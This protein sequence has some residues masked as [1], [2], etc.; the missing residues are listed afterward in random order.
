MATA[1]RSS[2]N[3]AV[4]AGR[5]ATSGPPDRPAVA[6][7]EAFMAGSRTGNARRCFM[8]TWLIFAGLMGAPVLAA[9]PQ[10]AFN[11]PEDAV[12]A[13]VGAVQK[14][15]R[16]ALAT[17][18]GPGSEALIRS[19]DAVKDRQEGQSFL[20]AYAAKHEVSSVDATHSVLHV[21]ANDWPLPI[22]IVQS[23]GKWRFDSADGAQQIIDRR[24]G[25]NEIA[26]I[27]FCL[28]YVDAQKAYFELFKQA[29]GSGA[30]AQHLV[31]TP[32]NYDGLYWPSAANIPDS[33]LAQVAADAVAE[34]YPSQVEA[35]KGLPY[36]GYFYRILTA[37][38]AAAPDGAKSFLHNGKMTEG[39]ALIAWPA[40]YGASGIMSF[41][42]NQDGIV[43]Q[44]DLG[45]NTASRVA[46]AKIFNPDLD[47]A[48]VDIASQ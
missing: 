11:S 27:E 8:A 34:G 17:V 40:R 31:S 45:P 6:R 48:R 1:R 30:Y 24:I 41:I 32:G 10:Q 22:P 20:D 42:V 15:D 47:W 5:W 12:A 37:Q 14:H 19:G 44:R 35:G 13:L 26:A 38:G 43:Y 29:T 28:A 3:A 7:V 23:N 2:D 36:Q 18:L 33:P 9:V 25:H 21:G 4:K 39:F 46:A 16:A